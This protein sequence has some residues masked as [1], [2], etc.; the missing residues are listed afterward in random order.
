MSDR[1]QIRP[2]I[3]V[4][5]AVAA[6]VFVGACGSDDSDDATPTST[7]RSTTTAPATTST[8]PAEGPQEWIEA[9]RDVNER[10]FALLSDPEPSRLADVYSE[11]CECWSDQLE[12]VEFL[13]ERDEHFEGEPPTVL[14]V[15]HEGEIAGEVH[16]LTVKARTNTVRRVDADGNA[17]QEIPA[18]EPSCMSI[19]LRAD[20]PGDAWRV[21]SQ[22]TL[23]QCPEGS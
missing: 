23:P 16:Q 11:T 8:V 9:V 14:F 15:R 22:T 2:A 20:G 17:V 1:R 4:L 19:G 21:Y 13:A 3:W 6:P 12:T 5:L 7:E 18:S 10:D